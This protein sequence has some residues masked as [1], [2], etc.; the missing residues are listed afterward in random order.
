MAVEYQEKSVSSLLFNTTPSLIKSI[1][2]R[3]TETYYP[4]GPRSGYKTGESVEFDIVCDQCLDLQSFALQFKLVVEGTTPDNARIAN[5][6][7]VIKKIEV[8]YNDVVLAEPNDANI[9]N[10]AF[11]FHNTNQNWMRS[12]GQIYMGI[13]NQ[14]V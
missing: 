13:N 14:F 3:I 6:A 7:D 2:H 10:N 1:S 5:A 8:F 12:D 4:R 9:W 11:L